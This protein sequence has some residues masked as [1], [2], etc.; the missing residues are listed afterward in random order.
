MASG[1]CYCFS[2]EGVVA[3][4]GEHYND[5]DDIPLKLEPDDA[6]VMKAADNK[7]AGVNVN[8]ALPLK[9]EAD[10]VTPIVMSTDAVNLLPLDTGN[11]CSDIGDK[12]CL[13]IQMINFPPSGSNVSS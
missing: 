13:E 1:V 7:V 12:C 5:I 9:L 10:N 6:P 11:Y 2:T 3:R 4:K 8:N